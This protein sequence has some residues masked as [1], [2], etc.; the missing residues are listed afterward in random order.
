MDIHQ[1]SDQIFTEHLQ[2]AEHQHG[3]RR[4]YIT[5]TAF[6]TIHDHIQRGLNEKRTNMR[7]VMAV[8]DLSRAFDTVN[9]EI[10]KKI[11]L[12]TTLPPTIKIWLGNYLSGR[13]IYDIQKHFPNTEGSN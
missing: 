12:E 2:L 1:K 5:T 10:L 7:T 11:I 13:H 6:H 3:F 9:I 8:L 4:M